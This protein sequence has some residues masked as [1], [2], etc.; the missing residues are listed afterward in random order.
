MA[1]SDDVDAAV[2]DALELVRYMV[3]SILGSDVDLELTTDREPGELCVNVHVP[4]D[5]RGRVIGRHGRA[6]RSMRN[7]LAAANLGLHRRVTLDIV[8]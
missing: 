6:A 5:Q 8:D 1:N 2:E 3:E 4:A 7:I